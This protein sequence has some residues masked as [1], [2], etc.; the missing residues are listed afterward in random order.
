[1]G[2]ELAN[3][4]YNHYNLTKLSIEDIKA[5]V[6]KTNEAVK[7]VTGVTPELVR[8]PYGSNN[9]TVL[10]TIGA[11]AILW[12]I[13]T[14]DWKTHDPEKIYDEDVGKVKDGDIVL[15]HDI[16]DDT[17]EAVEKIIP[18]LMDRGYQIVTVSEL[19]LYKGKTLEDGK[20]YYN[21][22]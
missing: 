16:H 15:M 20:I 21:L 17:A 10:E 5:Q 7:R 4:T 8:P 14:L 3:H 2:C 1:M 22:R 19:A 6:N 9:Q 18:E 13:D 12:N 11:P